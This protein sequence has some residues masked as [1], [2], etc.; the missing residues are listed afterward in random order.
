MPL[1]VH[2]KRFRVT[3]FGAKPNFCPV[4]GNQSFQRGPQMVAEN[5]NVVVGGSSGAKVSRGPTL[6]FPRGPRPTTSMR[7][8]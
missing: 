7:C 1:G 5:F 6:G 2:K 3:A 4:P 8:R